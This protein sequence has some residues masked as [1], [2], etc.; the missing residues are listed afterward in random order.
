[1][2][3]VKPSNYNISLF[4]LQR[5]AP[6]TYQGRVII[7]LAVKKPTRSLTFNTHELKIYATELTLIVDQIVSIIGASNISY[8]ENN[9]RCMLNFDQE[10]PQTEKSILSITFQGIMNDSMNGFY[11]SRYSPF[12][13]PAKAISRDEYHYM[14]STQF[15]PSDARR[16]FPCFDEPNLKATFDFEIEVPEELEALS[17]MPEREVKKSSNVGHKIVR[18]ERTP[19]MS[20]YLMAWALGDF[21]YI[22]EFTKRK[23]RG[24]SLPIRVY[25]TRGL[26]QQGK[27]ALECACRIIDYFS[28][29]RSVHGS[30]NVNPT[31][32]DLAFPHRLSF[33][34]G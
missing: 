22:E 14:F 29:V 17:N 20:T 15:Q 1:L 30:I 7:D 31:D 11:R 33:A 3:S 2:R 25:T 26:E 10:I 28:E 18:F 4:N 16:A 19:I 27:L 9:Q 8:D 21:G 5:K 34:Q 32:D 13:E 6:W 12:I 24:K 23:Y